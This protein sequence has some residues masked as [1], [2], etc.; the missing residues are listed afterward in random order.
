MM[1]GHFMREG[2][3]LG[4]VE[5]RMDG[6]RRSVDREAHFSFGIL[7][8]STFSKIKHS[9]GLDNRYLDILKVI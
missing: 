2:L 1:Q 5:R 9:I 6:G 3:T 8:R 4:S 7:D